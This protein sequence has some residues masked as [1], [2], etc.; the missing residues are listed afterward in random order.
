MKRFLIYAGA[1]LIYVGAA[2]AGQK[3]EESADDDLTPVET[4][5]NL[6]RTASIEVFTS[7]E[8]AATCKE[9]LRILKGVRIAAVRSFSK[10]AYVLSRSG[11]QEGDYS[12]T[13]RELVDIIRLRGLFNNRPRWYQTNDFI[14]RCWTAFHGR[15]IPLTQVRLYVVAAPV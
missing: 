12:Q 3:S 4:C 9:M 7:G 2:V 5:G 14:V 8:S 6:P 15:L 11:Y 10:A 1:L 13:V